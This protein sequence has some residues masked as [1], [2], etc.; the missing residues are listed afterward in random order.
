[1][2]KIGTMSVVGKS[3]TKYVFNLYPIGTNFKAVGAVYIITK[4]TAKPD[5]GGNHTSLYV[6]ETGDLSTRFDDHHKQ[7][8][9]DRNGAN[10][11]GA[12]QDG[13][14]D[15]RLSKE[16]DILDGNDWPCND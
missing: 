10:C 7:S 4:R 8:C 14:A 3:G 16:S 13:S 2:A 9:F 11:I 12:H 1:M 15:S 5:G 6:G